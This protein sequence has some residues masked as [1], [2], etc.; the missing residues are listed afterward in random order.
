MS[1]TATETVTHPAT[2][3]AALRRAELVYVSDDAP[4]LGRKRSGRGFSYFDENGKRITDKGERER[5][6][7]LAIPPA[8][9]EVWICPREDGHLL[10]TG[11]DERGRKQ[12]LYHP[13]WQRVRDAAKFEHMLAFGRLL[14][15]I[16][17]RV[18]KDLKLPGLPKDKVLAAVVK[19]L[20]TTLI[21]VGNA[22]YAKE[23]GSYGL[24][25]L[26][27][28]HVDVSGAS[29]TFD[30]IGKSGKEWEVELTDPQVARIVRTCEEI[31][32][33]EL[34]KY[35]DEAGE[36]QDVESADVND[37]LKRISGEDVTA[38][39]FRTWA[40]TVMATFTLTG[41]ERCESKTQATK[42]VTATIK[43]VAKKLGNTPAICRKSYVHPDVISCYL[44]GSLDALTKVEQAV[45]A[46]ARPKGL[47]A[48][49]MAVLRFLEER[50]R[51]A[52]G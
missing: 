47:R 3:P 30:F 37:Y 26:R 17:R 51:Q 25:T 31:P 5:L 44:D 40:G 42:N 2:D 28:K 24:T 52:S 9:T 1:A 10:A 8:W 49:E 22:T 4:G 12:Y 20:E 15:R 14:P 21:R 43:E 36:R 33:Y 29:V 18:Q 16:R 38:K 46:S 45:E 19:L 48:E 11:R 41:L 13:E 27:K 7:A 23:N 6:Q 32:G 35:L 50:A 34:F 39:D